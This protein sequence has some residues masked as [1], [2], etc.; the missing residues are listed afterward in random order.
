ME[1]GAP[2][3]PPVL[4]VEDYE[5]IGGLDDALS[6][7]GDEILAE[8][9]PEQQRIAEI[10]FR[11]LSGT[12]TVG[13]TCALPRES[14]KSPGL[15]ASSPTQVI[16][17]ADAF[18]RADRCFLAAPEGP[19]DEDTLLDLSH[20][21]LIRQ[22]RRLAGLG[23]RGGEVGRD[24]IGACVT[25]RCAGSRAM[26]SCGAARIWR[27]PSPGGSARPRVRPGRSAM[28]P[29]SNFSLQ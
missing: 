13:A 2:R 9:T 20:E 25:G 14:V 17:V 8:L 27:T 19:L 23:Q 3:K 6:N 1:S 10:M 29:V 4:T 7:H 22:W 12:R 11:R 15:L 26:P 24:A 28:V 18:R 16:A 21:S 5:A